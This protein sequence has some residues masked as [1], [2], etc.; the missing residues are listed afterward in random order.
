MTIAY[1][2]T[3]FEGW[4]SQM[5]RKAIQDVIEESLR[6]VFKEKIRL[7]GASRTDSGVHAWG[8]SAHFDAE[9]K[10]GV[11]KLLLAL[12]STLPPTIVI[13]SLRRVRDNFHARFDA[14]GKK[15]TYT[16]KTT[17]ASPFESRWM[18]SLKQSVGLSIDFELLKQALHLF[19]G[20]HDFS[21]FSGKVN[22]EETPTK[23]LWEV[24]AKKR[25]SK[26]VITLIGSGFLYKMARSIVG[27][28]IDVARKKIPLK[29]VEALLK[30]PERTHEIVTAPAKGLRLEKVFYKSA[31]TVA[32]S[33]KKQ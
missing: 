14:K 20:H 12:Q 24:S 25:G 29:R 13:R 17:A 18:W 8:Q 2:G 6:K 30:K 26:I 15:Y 22:E 16:I 19:E 31:Y 27:A 21:S 1:D 9:W 7:H 32:P 23:T 10:Y 4:Q 33:V 11:D 28:A 3:D 5:S